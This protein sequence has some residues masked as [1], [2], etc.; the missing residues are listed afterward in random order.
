MNKKQAIEYIREYGK[1]ANKVAGNLI[2]SNVRYG[3]GFEVYVDENN[4]I[5]LAQETGSDVPEWMYRYWELVDDCDAGSGNDN[6]NL[7]EILKAAVVKPAHKYDYPDGR[8][9]DCGCTVY[10][11]HE[12]MSA[13]LGTSCQNCY[14][15]MSD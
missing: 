9:L 10:F 5:W 4:T 8:E 6:A 11:S 7:I 1:E 3:V 15:R 13:S 2:F 12:V 14:D